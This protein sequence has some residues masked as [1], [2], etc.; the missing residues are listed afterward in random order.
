MGGV[1]SPVWPTPRKYDPKKTRT[2]YAPISL[3]VSAA[4]E[5]IRE[6][7]LVEKIGPGFQHFPEGRPDN[8]FEQLTSEKL[9][10]EYK[11]GRAIK[12]WKQQK[13]HANEALDARVY[14]YAALRGLMHVRKFR[15]EKRKEALA[16]YSGVTLASDENGTPAPAAKSVVVRPRVRKGSFMQ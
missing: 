4:K 1:W 3:G 8:Y 13:G 15:F 14:A 12:Y 10:L 6:L 7:L 2:G 16:A 11:N 5:A 9:L